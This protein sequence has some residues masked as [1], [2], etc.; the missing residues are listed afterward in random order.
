MT[1]KNETKR[2]AR[3]SY[4]WMIEATEGYRRA[5]TERGKRDWAYEIEHHLQTLNRC[6]NALAAA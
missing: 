1:N 2:A 6:R 5:K 4:K 3:N